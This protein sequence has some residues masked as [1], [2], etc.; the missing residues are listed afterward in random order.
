MFGV[1]KAVLHTAAVA[2][3]AVVVVAMIQ[4]HVVKVPVI[5]GYLPQ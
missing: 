4:R 1:N 5:G 3:A 2:L